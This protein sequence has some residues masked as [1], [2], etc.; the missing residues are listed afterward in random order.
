[1]STLDYARERVNALLDE[2][3]RLTEVE[4]PHEHSERALEQL[5]DRFQDNLKRLAQFDLKSDLA[6]VQQTCRLVLVDLYQYLPLLGFVLRSTNVRNAFEVFGPLLRL[7]GDILEPGVSAGPRK[8]KLLL[9]S[10]WDFSP[11]T[12]PAIPALPDFLFIDLPAPESSNPL[13]LPLAGHE[14]GH[15]VW[16]KRRLRTQVQSRAKQSTLD[17]I[18]RR[19]TDYQSVFSQPTLTPAELTTDLSG[20]IRVSQRYLGAFQGFSWVI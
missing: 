13:L 4:F 5:R 18:K 6:I 20:S 11:F 10:E 14:L 9:S 16:I 7:A 2:V 19:W 17:A 1:M 3:E 15:A 8:T 12:F